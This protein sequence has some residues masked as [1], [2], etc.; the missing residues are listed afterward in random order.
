MTPT[1]TA[2]ANAATPW[3]ETDEV[4]DLLASL[5]AT[6]PATAG[7]S[8]F[9]PHNSGKRDFLRFNDSRVDR[10]LAIH[11]AAGTAALKAS[12]ESGDES[13]FSAHVRQPSPQ[14]LIEQALRQQ[15]AA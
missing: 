2:L 4:R 7:Y 10:L 3:H 8:D 1:Q 9:D 13:I 14:H 12:D 15:V 5:A 11:K 6:R